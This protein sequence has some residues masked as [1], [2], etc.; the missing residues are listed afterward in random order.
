[1]LEKRQTSCTIGRNV[2]WFSHS[3]KQDGSSS[4]KTETEL[5][6]DPA[7]LDINISGQNYNSKRYIYPY[8]HSSTTH[9]S[10]DME[11]N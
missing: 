11:A 3:G 8:V 2:N 1:M 4:K 9:N 10:Q 7:I 5:P 6:Y